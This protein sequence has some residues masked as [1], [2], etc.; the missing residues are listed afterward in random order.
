MRKGTNYAAPILEI[1]R[2][3]HLRGHT[4]E[5]ACLDGYQSLGTSC[6]FVSKVHV[7]GRNIT[8]EEDAALYRMW[9]EAD[10]ATAKGRKDAVTGLAF[11][12]SFWTETYKNL[13]TLTAQSRPDFIL[14]DLLA[15][16]AVDMKNEY[17]IPLAVHYPQMPVQMA[18]SSYIPGLP[19]LQKKHL[20]T[21][22]A[23]LWDRIV[24]DFWM[25]KMIFSLKDFIIG[26]RKMRSAAGAPPFKLLRKPD[27]LVLVNSCFG[28]EVPKDLPPLIV[29]IGP[30]LSED[31]PSIGEIEGFLNSHKKVVYVAFGSHVDL[32]EYRQRRIA[33]GLHFALESGYIDG[34]IWAM[35]VVQKKTHTTT[36]ESDRIR[37]IKSQSQS[38][39]QPN[40]FDYNAILSDQHPHFRIL[41]WAPQRAILAHPSTALFI[42]H[43][44]ASSTMEGVYHGVPFI[45]IPIYGD[46]LG[47]AARI[48]HAGLGLK[49]DKHRFTAAKL[50]ACIETI[51]QD[52]D[53]SFAR[54]VLRM[55]RVATSTSKRKHLAA[56]MIEEVLYDH[57]L[58]FEHSPH[59]WECKRKSGVGQFENVGTELRPMHLQTADARMGWFRASN[60]DKTLV[61]AA[62]LVAIPLLWLSK[63]F[64]G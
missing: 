53:R 47:S 55:K 8:V 18:P 7:V 11:F 42:S 31:I 61:Y 16:A 57:E 25:M 9:D 15:V 40:T 39:P 12:E 45:A 22:H 44:G 43:C 24:E 33:E 3:L 37:Q 41:G 54:N 27:Y 1:C 59:D 64:W 21:E 46:Q 30:V 17:N 38:Y 19:G 49:L 23:T 20:T 35:K 58:R 36:A 50:Y 14:A 10:L 56:D 63:V 28:I 5:F 29:P 26:R 6:P 60:W 48:E 34:V 2:I 32:A 4:I 51:M 13:H 52:V 62:A